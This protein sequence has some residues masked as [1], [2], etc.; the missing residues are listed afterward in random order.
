MARPSVQTG[1]N[2]RDLFDHAEFY[3]KSAELL[4]TSETCRGKPI[5]NSRF[6]RCSS[7]RSHPKCISNAYTPLNFMERC[8][9]TTRST[10]FS[11]AFLL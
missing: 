9:S 6:R 10:S 2:P 4:G 11:V 1:L 8:P 3:R 5:Q 7:A